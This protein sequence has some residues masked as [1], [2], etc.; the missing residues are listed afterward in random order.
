MG[1]RGIGWRGSGT[2]DK[3]SGWRGGIGQESGGRFCRLE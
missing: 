3:E 1:R 2:E